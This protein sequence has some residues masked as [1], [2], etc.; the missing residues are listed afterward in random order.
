MFKK[1][2]NDTFFV[3]EL[4]LSFRIGLPLTLIESHG[5]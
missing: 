4:S 5:H 2:C 1:K 3:F